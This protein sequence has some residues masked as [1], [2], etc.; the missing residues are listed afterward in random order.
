MRKRK[1]HHILNSR[2]HCRALASDATLQ[3]WQARLPIQEKDTGQLQLTTREFQR[4]FSRRA[5]NASPPAQGQVEHDGDGE[6][7]AESE[8]AN[9]GD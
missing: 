9:L 7:E 4:T 2:P 8:I 1:R 5:C 3:S 6:R